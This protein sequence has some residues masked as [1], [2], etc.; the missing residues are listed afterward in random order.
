LTRP[1]E[2]E[3]AAFAKRGQKGVP[4]TR[5]V[6]VSSLKPDVLNDDKE[7]TMALSE[8]QRRAMNAKKRVGKPRAEKVLLDSLARHDP[9][10]ILKSKL[11]QEL[12]C[13]DDVDLGGWLAET[14]LGMDPVEAV[15][16]AM[17][18]AFEEPKDAA[19][20][21]VVVREITRWAKIPWKPDQEI[22][23]AWTQKIQKN[24][25]DVE[26]AIFQ[27]SR[28]LRYIAPQNFPQVIERTFDILG[29]KEPVSGEV[30]CLR[31]Y[32]ERRHVPTFKERRAL[33]A[34]DREREG[35]P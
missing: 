6:P 12:A 16:H 2:Q 19:E 32:L 8:K 21:E 15:G 3:K 11:A 24:L 23:R 1:R 22:L 26:D 9:K 34:R 20:L 30:A 10:G 25:E 29:D 27:A 28:N 17:R 14:E 13:N 31:R 4:K 35:G 7:Q 5:N 33:D 18:A